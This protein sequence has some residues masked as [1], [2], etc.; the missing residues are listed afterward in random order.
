MGESGHA[1]V[2]QITRMWTIGTNNPVIDLKAHVQI[3]SESHPLNLLSFSVLH[4]E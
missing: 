2:V 3:L 4:F 1:Y